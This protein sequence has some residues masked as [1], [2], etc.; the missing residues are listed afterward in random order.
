VRYNVTDDQL[1][2]A[3][4][5]I[6]PGTYPVRC[7]KVT[8]KASK[9]GNPVIW[10]TWTVEGSEPPAGAKVVENVTMTPESFFR[11]QEI[12]EATGFKGDGTGFDS[13]DLIGL[14]C[15]VAVVDDE[16]EGKV[17]SKVKAHLPVA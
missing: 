12:F 13:N 14:R 17:R 8:D 11:L 7:D 15:R 2:E 9:N 3:G 5:R 6:E 10:V 1:K 4:G 16:Y